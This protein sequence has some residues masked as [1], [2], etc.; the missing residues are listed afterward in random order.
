MK[1]IYFS[2]AFLV[3]L[4]L[5]SCKDHSI[6][7]AQDEKKIAQNSKENK[8]K[9]EEPVSKNEMTSPLQ[10]E[11]AQETSPYLLQHKNN[12][13]HWLPWGEKAFNLAKERDLP[14]LVSIGYSTCHWCHV[15]E[16][17]VFEKEEI[18]KLMNQW[19]ICIKVDREEHPE[20][21]EI[22]MNAVTAMG[23]GG[24]WPLN[25]FVTP[26]GVPF[27][28][29][30]YFPADHWVK[31]IESLHE[32]WMDKRAQINDVTENLKT[33]LQN[34]EDYSGGDVPKDVW[35]DL[36]NYLSSSFDAKDPAWG[37]AP[38]FPSAQVLRLVLTL[39]EES[40]G[41]KVRQ[42]A[43]DILTTMQD[44]G[45]QD[46]VGGGFHRYSVDTEW[47]VPHFEKMLY[48]NALLAIDYLLAG[49]QED[50][51]DLSMTGLRVLEYLY[52]D[53]RMTS[54]E[55][56]LL[57]Y[58]AAEDADDPGG[59]GSFYAW[60]PDQLKEVLGEELS[61]QLARAWNVTKD[62]AHKNHLGHDEP[63][64]GHIPFPR[65][66]SMAKARS[67]EESIAERLSWQKHYPKLLEV[68][69]KR[70]RPGLD[71]KVIT[72]WNGLAL[73]AFAYGA[74]LS[75]MEKYKKETELLAQAILQRHTEKGLLRLPHRPAFIND[76]GFLLCGLLD[77][78]DALGD[79]NLIVAAQK[80]ANEA[81]RDFS[82]PKGGFYA[83]P[84]DRTDLIRR[85]RVLFDNAY[86]SGN[87]AMALGLVRLWSV[88]GE[89]KYQEEASKTVKAIAQVASRAGISL[90]TILTAHL[91]LQRGQVT[92]VVAGE[93]DKKAELLA[94]CRQNTLLASVVD[95]SKAKD[96]SWSCLE[97][98]KEITEPTV[99][100]CVG[101]VCLKPIK[102]VAELAK[103]LEKLEELLAY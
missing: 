61:G 13:V 36:Q 16:H 5:F 44:S 10:N 76:Y 77:A 50:R 1:N 103:E 55:G 8:E 57:G 89:K 42:Q 65:G 37:R 63:I 49:A 32:T 86:P 20:V 2:F 99:L 58:A 51:S 27:F 60:S 94:A 79:P 24:G 68:R 62:H 7:E 30:T 66:S 96:E 25:V 33:Y 18:A 31:I 28:G 74:R 97:G 98:R 81:I 41:S 87:S 80:I 43:L 101:Q 22:Y 88:T 26:K 64:R 75:G 9:K 39:K 3:F 34:E 102:D 93:G 78:Y 38:K 45:L 11:L 6:S 4:S 73:S 47:R 54:K 23:Q 59:E 95:V 85:S 70:A 48:D 14:I 100:L 67:D 82:H 53:T 46:L 40:I 72:G 19:F 90:G 69:A 29:G 35:K 52:R 15:M 12:P 84:N 56:E 83:T 91:H 92:L 71:Y 21:D 17:E